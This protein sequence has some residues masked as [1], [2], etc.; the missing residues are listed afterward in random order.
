MYPSHINVKFDF[1]NEMYVRDGIIKKVVKF[2][3]RNKIK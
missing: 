2:L 3:K 1:E